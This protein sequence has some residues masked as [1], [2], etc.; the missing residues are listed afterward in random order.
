MAK[1]KFLDEIRFFLKKGKIIFRLSDQEITERL[2]VLSSSLEEIKKLKPQGLPQ[3]YP[4]LQQI[5]DTCINAVI[6][7]RSAVAYSKKW[8]GDFSKRY[9][10]AL[11]GI[12][13]I[14]RLNKMYEHFDGFGGC[15]FYY[16]SETEIKI[17]KTLRDKI[18]QKR[19][20]CTDFLSSSFQRLNPHQSSKYSMRTF[21]LPF[22]CRIDAL[23]RTAKIKAGKRYELISNLFY[24]VGL[25]R[26]DS[27]GE[28]RK[29]ITSATKYLSQV[30]PAMI[31]LSHLNSSISKL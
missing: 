16:I 4:L 12:D 21:L 26:K 25:E 2:K 23:L 31:A 29:R 27:V 14:I 11:N 18:V 24:A 28:I 17:L 20:D 5:K 13:A 30:D 19:D 15:E 8:K 6:K 3:N 9:K 10:D 22:Q 7:Y 1:D